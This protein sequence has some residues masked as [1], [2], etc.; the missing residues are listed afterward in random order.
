[1]RVSARACEGQRAV[2][3]LLL[4]DEKMVRDVAVSA[5]KSAGFAVIQAESAEDALAKATA[6]SGDIPLLITDHRLP[7][8]MTGRQ[9]AEC[10]LRERPAMRVLHMSGYPMA[11]LEAEG[12]LTRGGYYLAKP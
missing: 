10:L 3:I 12:S 4:D 7:G 6:Y 1:M 9:V 2:T 11:Q 5:L 8:G